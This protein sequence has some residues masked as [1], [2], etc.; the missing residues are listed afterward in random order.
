[1]NMLSLILGLQ[2]ILNLAKPLLW[3]QRVR[4]WREVMSGY[5]TDET[6]LIVPKLMTVYGTDM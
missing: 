2:V 4:H 1:M 3:L 5:A 6:Q